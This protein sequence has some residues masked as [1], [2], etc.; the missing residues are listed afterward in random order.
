MS[1]ISLETIKRALALQPFDSLGAQLRMTPSHRAIRRLESAGGQPRLSAVLLL[2]Y[3]RADEWHVL[4]TRRRDDLNSH[5]GQI[6]FPGG[7]QENT[8][9]LAETAFRE[10]QEEVGLTPEGIQLLGELATVYIP[11]SDFEVH[12]FVAYQTGP[13]RFHPDPGEVAELLE[14]PLSL[15]LDPETRQVEVW[16]LRELQVEVPYYR[17]GAHKVWGATAMMLGEF[18]DRLRVAIAIETGGE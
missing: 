16:E 12:P 17:I 18:L 2:L 5:A 13:A 10:T 4:L 15:L 11:P 8:E 7:R 3:C 6:S 9:S 1:E 14:T